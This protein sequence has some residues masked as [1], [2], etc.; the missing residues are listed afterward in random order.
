M[1]ISKELENAIQL[2]EQNGYAVVKMSPQ[3]QEDAEECEKLSGEGKDKDCSEC[4]CAF[5]IIQG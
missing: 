4:S 2:L 5:C 3:M 1:E